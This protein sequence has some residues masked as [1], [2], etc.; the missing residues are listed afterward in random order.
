[1]AAFTVIEHLELGASGAAS[2]TLDDDG[3]SI[4]TD[5]TYDHLLILCSTRME[6]STYM[7]EGKLAFNGVMTSTEYSL[8]RLYAYEYGGT[9]YVLSGRDTTSANGMR[10]DLSA[11][12]D[13]AA[14]IFS[15]TKIWVP[16]FAGTVGNKQVLI[17]TVSPSDVAT[18]YYWSLSM[19]AGLW[20]PATPA[21]I[22]SCT[23][24]GGA[25]DFAQYSEFTLYGV[26]GA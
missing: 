20:A 23:F 8:T 21:A 3:S 17:Q 26:K 16:N 6:G 7:G 10:A 1:M 5:G 22:T 24:T 11:G 14:G 2:V 25:S 9:N 19:R 12:T 15:S 13:Q 18:D 4:P